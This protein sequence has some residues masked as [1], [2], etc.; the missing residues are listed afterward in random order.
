MERYKL[1]W[2]VTSSSPVVQ[3]KA[4][5][6]IAGKAGKWQTEI[7]DG[8]LEVQELIKLRG[9]LVLTDEVRLEAGVERGDDGG[10]G[11][12]PDHDEVVAGA[13]GQTDEV[14][15]VLRLHR[16]DVAGDLVV[17]GLAAVHLA[18]VFSTLIGPAPT[19][20]PSHWSRA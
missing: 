2:V 17:A 16:A 12:R 8:E 4:E 19:R 9:E 20:L 18:P 11:V 1:E 10:D 13:A 6:K 3:F 15:A 5:W 14:L 7:V